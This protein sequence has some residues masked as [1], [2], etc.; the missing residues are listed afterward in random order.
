MI[1]GIDFGTGS[2]LAVHGPSG[3]ISKRALKLPKVPGGRTPAMEFPLV[4]EALFIGSDDVPGGDVVVESPTL[5]SSGCERRHI[6]DLLARHP[7]RALFT[8]SARA[9]KNFRKD[10]DL[11]WKKGARY[12]R[13]GDP[14]PAEMTLEEQA[15][16]HVEEAEIIY[17]IATEYPDRLYRWTGPSLEIERQFTSV[18]PMDKHLYRPEHS[19]DAAR[20]LA[21]LP[22]FE[23]L[24]G[25]LRAVLGI[26]EGTGKNKRLGY[27]RSMVMPFAMATQEPHVDDGP[28]ED[29]RKRYEKV[30]GLYDRGY[31]SF[32]RRATVDWMHV[33]AK[34]LAEATKIEEVTR[35]QRKLAW[36]TTQRQIRWFF[37]LMMAHQGR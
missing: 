13:D 24:P 17:R 35:E 32:Y 19:P 2:A 18:R 34:G 36:K 14:A 33:V 22:P 10:H 30:I 8:V 1:Y 25:E 28:I 4:V 21:L 23:T 3:P 16:V 37:H 29:R 11:G 9:V 7:D 20:F 5:G 15:S 6:V 26:Y 27:S 12:V 31:P